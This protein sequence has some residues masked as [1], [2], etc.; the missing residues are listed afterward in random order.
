MRSIAIIHSQIGQKQLRQLERASAGIHSKVGD[1]MPT[2][3]QFIVWIVVGLLG[4]SLAG[5]LIT[6]ERKGFGLVRNLAVGLIGALVGGL[7]SRG[8]AFPLTRQG[9]DLVARCRGRRPRIAARPHRALAL[10]ALQSLAMTARSGNVH[11]AR[12]HWQM[13]RTV[14]HCGGVRGRSAICHY[15]LRRT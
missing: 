13:L 2:I 4:G 11:A 14:G 5:L 8:W 12:K 6:W 3:D 10:G 15:T 1:R 7:L 9:L